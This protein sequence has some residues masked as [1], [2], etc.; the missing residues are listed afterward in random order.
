MDRPI[1]LFELASLSPEARERLLVR[2][3]ADLAVFRELSTEVI[4]DGLLET[5]V[6]EHDA[7]I[8][9]VFER[10]PVLPLRFGTVVA[11]TAAA[12][13]LL[14]ERHQEVSTWLSRVACHR[15]WG[16]RVEYEGMSAFNSAVRSSA[17]VYS[18]EFK[19]GV[20]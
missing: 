13:Q 7:V 1:A 11:D 9:A 5:L 12:R 4:E 16:L 14:T 15:E 20:R 10:E 17:I 3:E 18:K 8:R 6:R 19:F 2:S